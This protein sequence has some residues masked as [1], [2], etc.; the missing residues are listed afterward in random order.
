M[1][2]QLK[3]L[4]LLFVTASHVSAGEYEPYT[5]IQSI[6][7]S[8]PIAI[9]SILGTWAAPFKGG[10]KALTYN[11]AELG[12]RRG[13]WQFGFL[14]RYDYQLEFS[15]ETAELI[16]RIQNRLP[17]E[18]GREY[19]LR[20]KAQ[21]NYSRGLRLAYQH[22]FSSRIRAGIAASY[23]QGKALTD[24]ALQGSAQV[25][26]QKD[27]DF[28]FDVDYFYSRDVLFERDVTSPSGEGY[29]LD[30]NIDWQASKRFT[31]QLSVVDL[32]G[33]MF[34]D[35]APFTIATATSDTK[36]FDADGYVQYQPAISGIESNKNFTQTLP[37]KI[38]IATQYQWSPN[39]GLLA[40]L[41]DYK[42]A[43]FVSAGTE[44]C[45][46]HNDC[47]QGLYNTTASALSLRYLGH[48][49]RIELASD[50]LDLKQARYFVIQLSF[51]QFF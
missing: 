24:G 19:E 15:P 6:F 49:L 7:Y 18:V 30:F 17:L 22:K 35:N 36:T 32:I 29:S 47:F 45:Y 51:N 13:N 14:E 11:K 31:A 50:K 25:T 41:Q 2:R 21:H 27:Y 16:Y 20:I 43:R 10:D 4:L 23:L 9:Q 28:Q 48:G 37:R 44:W 8:E 34:W 12:V 42:V 38:F 1:H 40:E 3:L 26:A 46:K 5:N 39:V 33:K